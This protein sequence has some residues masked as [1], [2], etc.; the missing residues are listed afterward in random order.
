[1]TTC[2]FTKNDTPKFI[3]CVETSIHLLKI[4]HPSAGRTQ[5]QDDLIG[6]LYLPTKPF[7]T[8]RTAAHGRASSQ[9]NEVNNCTQLYNRAKN[10]YARGHMHPT[11]YQSMFTYASIYHYSSDIYSSKFSKT[12]H[13][14]TLCWKKG[15]PKNGT[16]RTFI[17]GSYPPPPREF[18][19]YCGVRI[20]NL[21]MEEVTVPTEKDE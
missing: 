5:R 16:S 7:F 1:M 17:Y 9:V 10:T 21:G 6:G 8:N 11:I 18:S 15:T 13:S 12:E 20:S 4:S 2:D 19:R 14:S 3:L